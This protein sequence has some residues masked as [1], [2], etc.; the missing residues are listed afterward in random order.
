VN[1]E[2]IAS[3]TLHK[4]PGMYREAGSG[5][6]ESLLTYS[7][8]L[9]YQSFSR[10]REETRRDADYLRRT[11]HEQGHWSIAEHASASFLVKGV[12]RNMLLELERHRHLSFSVISQRFVNSA[13]TPFVLPPALS[14][15]SLDEV[16]QTG[17]FDASLS[18][19]EA[20]DSLVQLLTE[21]GLKRK[22]AREAARC[23][24]PG[25]LETQFVVTGNLR[26]WHD[27]LT[28]RLDPS[29]DREIREFASKVLE[30][31]RDIAPHVYTDFTD[32]TRKEGLSDA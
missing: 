29:A 30:G 15:L 25:G 5:D 22:E 19:R 3:T 13:D 6:A 4:T 23:I 9:C 7:G 1:V 11:L 31:L 18:A 10:P 21:K 8:R 14:T 26:A 17:V 24:L 27:V 12:S 32:D 2:L 20:Y 16:H 28:K